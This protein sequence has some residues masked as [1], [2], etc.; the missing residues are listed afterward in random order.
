MLISG[1]V[2]AHCATSVLY[3]HIDTG[4]ARKKRIVFRELSPAV[5]WPGWPP[6]AWGTNS[7]R[8]TDQ[9]SEAGGGKEGGPIA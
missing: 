5:S 4:F 1:F 7:A 2:F 6:S 3:F 8:L 9:G